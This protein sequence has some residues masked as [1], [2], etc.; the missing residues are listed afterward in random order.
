MPS[1]LPN[2]LRSTGATLQSTSGRRDVLKS[3]SVNPDMTHGNSERFNALIE[4]GYHLRILF[5][6]WHS[7]HNHR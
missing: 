3:R 6:G 1:P 7:R 5:S 4:L 2:W